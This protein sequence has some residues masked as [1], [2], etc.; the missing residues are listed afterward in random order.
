MISY[1]NW[2]KKT[3]FS[4][5]SL[6][7]G[8]KKRTFICHQEK[9]VVPKTLQYCIVAWY[10]TILCHYGETRTKM[11]LWHSFGGQ[12]DVIAYTT[13]AQ[14]EPKKWCFYNY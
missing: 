12:M 8:G 9:I 14:K 2:A 1:S 4:F 3:V 5:K 6:L 13:C 10:H 7:G 11:T